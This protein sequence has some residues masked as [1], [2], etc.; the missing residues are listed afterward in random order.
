MSQSLPIQ[1]LVLGT[2]NS[3][4]P[5]SGVPFGAIYLAVDSNVRW[6]WNGSEWSQMH[7]IDSHSGAPIMLSY[8]HHQVYQGNYYRAGFAYSLGNAEVATLSFVTPAAPSGVHIVWDLTATADGT[9]TV[10]ESVSSFSGG[11]AVTPINH[12]RIST[13]ASGTTVKKGM[14]GS[15]LITPTGGSTLLNV[16]LATGK[17]SSIDRDT[18]AEFIFKQGNNYFF[19]YTNG[20]NANFVQLVLTWF[21]HE[22]LA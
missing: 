4:K 9:F 19:R 16:V 10:L 20:V 18:G 6:I 12:N 14:T 8:E 5:T 3:T 7:D 21:E 15:D 22:D 11:A 2:H 1:D 13:N 17:G